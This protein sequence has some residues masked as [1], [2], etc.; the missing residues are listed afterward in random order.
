MMAL[1]TRNCAIIDR[2]RRS[3]ERRCGQEKTHK[4]N[5]AAQI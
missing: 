2:F 5:Q 4:K 3:S 1:G